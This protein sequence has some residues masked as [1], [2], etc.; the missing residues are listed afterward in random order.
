M[1]ELANVYTEQF[2]FHLFSL[3]QVEKINDPSAKLCPLKL[4]L[5]ECWPWMVSLIWLQ[6]LSLDPKVA[7]EQQ[8][9]KGE[10]RERREVN[11][12][13]SLNY[14]SLFTWCSS[15]KLQLL[16]QYSFCLVKTKLY[17]TCLPSHPHLQKLV[18]WKRTRNRR[19]YFACLE[20]ETAT[21]K[22]VMENRIMA[23]WFSV[24]LVLCFSI[25]KLEDGQSNIDGH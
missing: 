1:C 21:T 13:Q 12:L 23:A 14:F 4:F 10:K 9:K 6:N 18:L 24:N 19:T 7:I 17:F 20:K 11:E 25:L 8:M 5:F 22:E 16:L 2:S 3:T 15:G